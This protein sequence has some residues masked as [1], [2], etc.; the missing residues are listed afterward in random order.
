MAE[1][2]MT[3]L[4][5]GQIARELGRETRTILEDLK[6]L[7]VDT[8]RGANTPVSE[9]HYNYL[10]AKYAPEKGRKPTSAS[11]PTSPGHEKTTAS[12]RDKE[13][14]RILDRGKTGALPGDHRPLPPPPPQGIKPSP[15]SVGEGVKTGEALVIIPTPPIAT[16][17][18][19]PPEVSVTAPPK[20]TPAV[21]EPPPV[22]SVEKVDGGPLIVEPK[23][24]PTPPSKVE[25]ISKPKRKVEPPK[26]A[27]PIPI[28][29]PS[30]PKVKPKVEVEELKPESVVDE[31]ETQV[32]QKE[33]KELPKL[34]KTKAASKPLE[35]IPPRRKKKEKEKEKETPTEKPSKARK[36]DVKEVATTIKKTM[37]AM[38]DHSKKK[39][40]RERSSSEDKT[41]EE[42]APLRV[43]EF[44]TTAELANL[45]EI[46][47]AEVIKKALGMGM[48]V[49]MNQRLDRDQIVL[50]AAEFGIDVEFIQEEEWE[51]EKEEVTPENLTSRQ[52]VVTVMGHVDH[53]KTTLLDYLRRTRVAESEAGGITQHIGAYEVD[54]QGNRIT[55]LD[56]PGH[57]A[58]TAMRARGAQITDI[59]VLVVAAD[60]RVMPQTIEAIDHARAAGVPIVVAVNKIDKPTANPDAIYQ[61]LADV[62][63]LI[64]KWGGKYQSAEISAKFGIGV[65]DL[66]AEILVAAELL[67]LKA[68]A[69]VK[70]RG[71]VIES[72]LDKGLGAVATILIQQ[73]TLKV[74]DSFVCGVQSGRVRMMMNDRG[75]SVMEMGPG[76]P[77][78]VVGFDG[79][80]QAG[81]KLNVVSSEKE[82]KAIALKRQAQYRELAIRHLRNLSLNQMAKRLAEKEIKELA[83]IIKADAHGSV[84]ALADGLMRLSNP[85]VSVNVVHRGVGAISESDVLLAAASQAVIIGFHVHPHPQARELARREGVEIRTYRIIHEVLDDVRKAM[86]GMLAPIREEKIVGLIEVRRVFRISKVGTVAGCY[87]QEGKV[88]RNSKLR[89]IRD[90]V[91]LWSGGIRSLKRFK[92][93]VREVVA[94]F[95]CGISLEGYDDVQEGDR[96][97]VIEIVETARK[98]EPVM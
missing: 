53:G 23:A 65:D 12:I 38:E 33:L 89:L 39:Y 42:V 91:E 68:D 61:Q 37:A 64:E 32:E 55:F 92:D 26:M 50:L 16:P 30:A 79:V 70:A 97:E 48:L 69:T 98:L 78:Q 80:P 15:P 41:A 72:R 1:T 58:F 2:S 88:M 34:I 28:I 93:D 60:D 22:K 3:S 21:K 96:L 4:K 57:E 7:G 31:L 54:Y 63:V 24:P 52:P 8:V 71:V 66:L 59:V 19:K 87:V 44:I 10:I 18:V 49:T 75:E 51:E 73:G 43:T 56:T 76:R 46:P 84:E 35:V 9:E 74:G 45:M 94:G 83:L 86:E 29:A 95:E 6:K 77:V 85:E 47:V 20:V 40:R 36:V 62:G 5:V 81:D 90:G 13:F 25:K 27:I 11:S 82:A 17:V 14:I 67:E